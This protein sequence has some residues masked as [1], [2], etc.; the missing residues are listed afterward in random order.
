[1]VE[2]IAGVVVAA[3]PDSG[4]G[5]VFW[6]GLLLGVAVGVLVGASLAAAYVTSRS[7]TRDT[8]TTSQLL[9]ASQDRVESAVRESEARA[10]ADLEARR[11]AVDDLVTP[12]RESLVRMNDALTQAER[13]RI[14]AH[15]QLHTEV[16]RTAD[17][18]EHL[19]NETNRLVTALRRSE[20]RGRWGEVQLRRL[21]ESAGMLEH[22]DFDEQVSVHDDDG[23]LRPDVLVHLGGGR[24]V[25][26]DAKAPLSAYLDAAMCADPESAQ[27][28]L[29]KHAEELRAHIDALSAKQYW[30]QFAHTP[31]FVVL[32]LPAEALLSAALDVVPSLLER[33]FDKKVVIATPTTL[34]ALLRTIEYGWRQEAMA[35]NAREIQ[36]LGSELHGRLG[37]LGGHIAKLGSAL[38][39]AV[40]SYNSAI[41]S[42]ESRVL[43]SAR[44]FR[45]LGVVTESL[46]D[47]TPI[48]TRTRR[49]QADEYDEA[50]TL[51]VGE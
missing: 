23:L 34:L 20:V 4:V 51:A 17:T 14:A 49:P 35:A 24:D 5:G 46:S 40:T 43:V 32:F 1:M 3:G 28:F 33:S 38:D 47:P 50:E 11:R 7:R 29:D 48:T 26:I 21:I 31:E 44:R 12:L 6:W 25:V 41:S 19:R 30:K 10:A 2:T 18:S 22:V 16:R 42:L 8:L 45:D 13:D 15:A 27:P 36:E 9:A 37:T 39:S